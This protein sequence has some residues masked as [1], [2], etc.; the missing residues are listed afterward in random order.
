MKDK[1]LKIMLMIAM[2]FVAAGCGI[3]RNNDRAFWDIIPHF[4]KSG[5]HVDSVNPLDTSQVKAAAAFAFTI[6][7]RQV[8]VYKYDSN[9]PKHKERLLR[10]DETGVFYVMGI[11]YQAIRNGSYILIDFKNHPRKNEIVKAFETF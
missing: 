11:R 1:L 10:V 6:G 3:S 5:V 2:L 9:N 4:E 7:E 8:G